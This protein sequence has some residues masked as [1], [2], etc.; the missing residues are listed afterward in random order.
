M[1]GIVSEIERR[2][3]N[4]YQVLLATMLASMGE[5]RILSYVIVCGVMNDVGRKLAGIYGRGDGLAG[6]IRKVAELFEV[7]EYELVEEEGKVA[8]KVKTDTCRICP[9]G[10]GGL[11][12][13]EKLCPLVGLLSGY[14]GVNHRLESHRREG[15][16]CIIEFE[17]TEGRLSS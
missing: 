14:A 13:P 3:A 5:H 7:G 12:L 16:Y 6:S 17:R 15:G 4:P 8:F 1:S 11:T 9:K 10:V 2:G